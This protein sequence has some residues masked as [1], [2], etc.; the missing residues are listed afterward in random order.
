MK[1]LALILIACTIG[2]GVFLGSKLKTAIEAR[3]DTLYTITQ[4]E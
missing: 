3:A 2:A 4:G 1:T